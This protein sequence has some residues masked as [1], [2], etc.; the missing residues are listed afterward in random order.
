MDVRCGD[1]SGTDASTSK[2]TED[3]QP[4]AEDEVKARGMEIGDRYQKEHPPKGQN[5]NTK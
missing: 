3:F 2:D 5:G 4:I 1:P